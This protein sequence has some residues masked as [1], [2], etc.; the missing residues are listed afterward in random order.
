[1]KESNSVVA[2]FASLGIHSG[3]RQSGMRLRAVDFGTAEAVPLSKDNLLSAKLE[4]R[5]GKDN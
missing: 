4:L 1:V 2:P 5:L 3:L